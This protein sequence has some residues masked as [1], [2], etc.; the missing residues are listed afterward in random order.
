M[1]RKHAFFNSLKNHNTVTSLRSTV[2]IRIGEKLGKRPVGDRCLSVAFFFPVDLGGTSSNA[3]LEV[4][5]Q[6]MSKCNHC[7][8]Y[9]QSQFNFVVNDPKYAENDH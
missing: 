3:N 6:S 1:I 4:M 9:F 8:S 2:C 7:S 5:S